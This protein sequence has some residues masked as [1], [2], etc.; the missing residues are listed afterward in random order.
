VRLAE[1]KQWFSESDREK[2]FHFPKQRSGNWPPPAPLARLF[3]D[4]EE[5]TKLW[6]GGND[7]WGSGIYGL[8]GSGHLPPYA[9]VGGRGPGTQNKAH[10]TFW[11]NPDHGLLLY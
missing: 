3:L 5:R 2:S 4:N 6:S 7:N 1:G 11:A 9:R 10:L 8:N